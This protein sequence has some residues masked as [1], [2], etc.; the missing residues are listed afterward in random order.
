MPPSVPLQ[1][2]HTHSEKLLE[3]GIPLQQK[4]PPPPLQEI[5]NSAK[6]C[7]E[8]AYGDLH[9]LLALEYYIKH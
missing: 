3:M 8:I 2:I 5:L 9:H 4:Y 1:N 6:A 7:T